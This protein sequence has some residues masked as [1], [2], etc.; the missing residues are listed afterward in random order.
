MSQTI[1]LLI[2]SSGYSLANANRVLVGP[3]LSPTCSSTNSVYLQGEPSQQEHSNWLDVS[4]ES[5]GDRVNSHHNSVTIVSEVPPAANHL[6]VPLEE[7]LNYGEKRSRKVNIRCSKYS[8]IGNPQARRRKHSRRDVSTDRKWN[9]K[10][11]YADGNAGHGRI[12]KERL[13]FMDSQSSSIY[14]SFEKWKIDQSIT[15][16][17]KDEKTTLRTVLPQILVHRGSVEKGNI[18]ESHDQKVSNLMVKTIRY[19]I[20]RYGIM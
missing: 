7:I 16:R 15:P 10:L 8:E 19:S 18:G 1:I 14:N 5:S 3:Q 20:L 6:Y 12:C 13:N 17:G 11:S 4:T 2:K 9:R